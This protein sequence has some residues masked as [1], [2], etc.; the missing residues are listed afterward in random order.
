MKKSRLAIYAITVLLAY[1]CKDE[2]FSKT[3]ETEIISNSKITA[4]KKVTKTYVH[5]RN[6]YDTLLL[7]AITSHNF[8]RVIN[9]ERISTNQN[10]YSNSMHSWLHAMPDF[11]IIEKEISVIENNTYLHWIG[12]GTNTEMFGNNPPT[13][14]I[15]HTEGLSILTF[16]SDGHIVHEATYFDRLQLLEEWGYSMSPPIMN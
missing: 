7:Q 13:G 8:V 15:G 9:G 11:K 4:L 10:K 3:Q 14:K 6:E 5:A 16:D 1:G 2:N 12:T